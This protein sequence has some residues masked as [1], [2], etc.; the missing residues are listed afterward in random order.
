MIPNYVPIIRFGK[1]FDGS[2]KT[3]EASVES[4]AEWKVTNVSLS[5]KDNKWKYWIL[6]FLYR[7]EPKPLISLHKQDFYPEI[8]QKYTKQQRWT[9]KIE[10][11]VKQ[12]LIFLTDYIW[13]EKFLK[14]S[15]DTPGHWG[16]NCHKRQGEKGSCLRS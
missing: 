13:R 12:T 5:P 14:K 9:K 3:L 15:R 16:W 6:F 4:D 8:Y 11:R 1:S 7:L 2:S 10:H